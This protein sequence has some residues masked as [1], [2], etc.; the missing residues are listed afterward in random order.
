[1]R[2]SPERLSFAPRAAI[3]ASS[4]SSMVRLRQSNNVP[5]RPVHFA[6]IDKYSSHAEL[7]GT[8]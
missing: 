8:L 2:S 1:M 6:V 7:S 4:A 5:M 3:S